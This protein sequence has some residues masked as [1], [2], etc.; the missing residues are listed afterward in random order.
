MCDY[1]KSKL[2]YLSS[3]ETDAIYIGSTTRSLS[4][5]LSEHRRD[6]KLLSEGIPTKAYKKTT[7]TE[8]TQFPSFTITLLEAFPCANRQEL[9][10]RELFHVRQ[11]PM[12]VNRADP[13]T[14]RMFRTVEAA[15]ARGGGL[16]YVL[17]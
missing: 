12:A 10:A 6:W 8:V 1:S 9:H 16:L 15:V 4:A 2:Y 13:M 5:R 14:G 11:C 7:A 17:A 3:P